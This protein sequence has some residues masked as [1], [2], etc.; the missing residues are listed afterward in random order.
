V[1]VPFGLRLQVFYAAG[2]TTSAISFLAPLDCLTV[3]L[4]KG[5]ATFGAESRNCGHAP[6]YYAE[7][8]PPAC[9][10]YHLEHDGVV[11][12]HATALKQKTGEIQCSHDQ[13]PPILAALPHAAK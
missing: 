4:Q 11:C 9:Q 6:Y 10:K 8:T 12:F 3:D 7:Q 13:S 1:E 5:R 2:Q